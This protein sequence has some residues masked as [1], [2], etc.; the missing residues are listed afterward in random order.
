M[1]YR[2]IIEHAGERRTLKL[3]RCAGVH[4]AVRRAQ[5][6]T[7]AGWRLIDVNGITR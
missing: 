6:I 2:A 5:A 3:G 7:P 4:D 1:T